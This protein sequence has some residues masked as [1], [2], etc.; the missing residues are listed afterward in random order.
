MPN[1]GNKTQYEVQSCKV[2]VIGPLKTADGELGGAYDQPRCNT[3]GKPDLC[4]CMR[5][6][7][8]LHSRR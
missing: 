4:D 3:I 1:P 5:T 6:L 8:R 7:A 2:G